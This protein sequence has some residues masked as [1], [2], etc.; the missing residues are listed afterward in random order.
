MIN[1]WPAATLMYMK[2]EESEEDRKERGRTG[3]DVRAPDPL[4]G[5]RR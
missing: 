2:V 5:K 3:D 1:L 4:A